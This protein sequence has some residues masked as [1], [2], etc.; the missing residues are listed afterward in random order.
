VEELLSDPQSDLHVVDDLST[1]TL[2]VDEFVRNGA[3][4]RLTYSLTTVANYC[5]T[6]GIGPFD[7]I[8]HLASV[9]G[10]AGILV[11]AGRIVRSIVS[12]TYAILD[13]A[14][15]WQ[16]K[17]LDVSTSEVYGGGIDGLC[18]E[19]T[20]RIVPS[21]TTV[22]L[23]YAVGKI[24]AETALVNTCR[25][26]DL[27][28]VIVRPFNIAG[29]R[30]SFHGGFVLARFARQALLGQPLTVFGDGSQIRAFTHVKDMAEGLIRAMRLGRPAEV[31]NLG[32]PLNRLTIG[33][34]AQ[35]VIQLAGTRPGVAFVDPKTIFGP[36]YDEAK[37]KYPDA[38][39]AISELGWKPRYGIDDVIRDSLEYTRGELSRG[40]ELQAS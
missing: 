28:G 12:D 16:A 3:R 20:P 9:V 35:R 30:Q 11:H 15:E 13:R 24:A 37:D 6:P 38:T 4:G 10:P 26:R 34:L 14:M 21:R 29:P 18:S 2:D 5:A 25:V 27:H 17:L 40:G 32:N 23:E 33:E 1:S 8:Y 39:K 31:Y 7:E 19:N 36:L 22:R